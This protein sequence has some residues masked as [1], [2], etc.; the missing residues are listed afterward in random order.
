MRRA[1][2]DCGCM[3]VERGLV[4]EDAGDAGLRLSRPGHGSGSLRHEGPETSERCDKRQAV[5]QAVG[6]CLL[7]HSSLLDP[8]KRTDAF[9][10]YWGQDGRMKV[11]GW[12]GREWLGAARRKGAPYSYFTYKLR[13]MAPRPHGYC[14]RLR[15]MSG[16][17]RAG[18]RPW[19]SRTYLHG[20]DS[21][22]AALCAL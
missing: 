20:R 19:H 14:A 18:L 4:S 13:A 17:G 15:R 21:C 5:M 16:P 3:Y 22:G 1:R 6:G 12:V 7:R 2:H 9:W 10:A 11:C 8:R